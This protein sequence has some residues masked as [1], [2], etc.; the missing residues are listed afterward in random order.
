MK[1]ISFLGTGNMGGAIARAVCKGIDP[2]EVVLTDHDPQKAAALAE[3]TGACTA[4]SNVEAVRQSKFILIAVKP[5]VGESVLKEIAPALRECLAAGE[6][7]VLIS[8]MVSVSI[9]TIRG[10][11][12]DDVRLPII[13]TLPNLAASVGQ[14]ITLCAR[15]ELVTD[16]IFAEYKSL[17]RLTGSF[18][19]LPEQKMYAGSV[20]TGCGPAFV[21]M[22]AQALADGGVAT[23]LTRAQAQSFAVET[24]LGT[25]A[26]LKESGKHPEQLKDEVCSPGGTT[27]AGVVSLEKNGFR[28][29][30]VQCVLDTFRRVLEMGNLSENDVI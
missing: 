24:I 18:A 1:K 16:A 6:E 22:F 21:C 11:L 23:G 19:E 8:I 5:Q 26:L 12:G 2:Q 17:L 3:E 13:R 4:A 25:A 15:G 14:C 29:A 28:N 27:I 9:E 10:W 30:A 7:K 20:I